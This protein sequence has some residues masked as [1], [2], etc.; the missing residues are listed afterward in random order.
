[1]DEEGEHNEHEQH[2]EESKG[3]KK[4]LNVVRKEEEERGMRGWERSRVGW[5]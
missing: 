3:D 1:M 5:K 2:A 4:H